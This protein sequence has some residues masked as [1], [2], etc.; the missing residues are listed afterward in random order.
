MIKNKS[1]LIVDDEKNIRLLFEEELK[2]F[3]YAVISAENGEIALQLFKQ[4]NPDLILLDLKMPGMHGVE[5]LEKIRE[6]DK[7]VPVII[8]TAHG[9][10][11]PI[12]KSQTEWAIKEKQLNI[13]DYITKPVDLDE[14][15]DKIR[16]F[17]GPSMV[18]S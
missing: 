18:S 16:K 4:T 7:T 3:G 5:T 10:G 1:I 15:I 6:L 12:Q 11:K 2:D 9:A 14:L 17:I 13:S 8:V